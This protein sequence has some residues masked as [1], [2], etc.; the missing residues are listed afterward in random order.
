MRFKTYR[1]TDENWSQDRAMR[2]FDVLA[3]RREWRLI[4]QFSGIWLEA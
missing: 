3:D 1:Q 4:F 2:A